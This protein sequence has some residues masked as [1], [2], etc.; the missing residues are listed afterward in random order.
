MGYAFDEACD[1]DFI[2]LKVKRP[3]N[4]I[5]TDQVEFKT[6]FKDVLIIAQRYPLPPIDEPE[7]VLDRVAP[8]EPFSIER[9]EAEVAAVTTPIKAEPAV[10]PTAGK[11]GQPVPLPGPAPAAPA[12]EKP[13]SNGPASVAAGEGVKSLP[14]T[15]LPAKVEVKPPPLP[16]DAAPASIE[17]KDMILSKRFWG[18]SV[19]ALGTTNL[20]PQAAQTWINNEG[21]RELITWLVVVLIGF[22]LYK[23]GQ[24]KAQKPLK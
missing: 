5:G 16:K 15:T 24:H 10:V 14:P 11:A 2:R 19:T 3:P 18:L 1:D 20:L 7:L 23:Y 13:A 9:Y 17:P 4:N 6:P 12:I 21:N 22:A 8:A